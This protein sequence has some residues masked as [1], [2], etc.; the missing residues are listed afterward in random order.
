[1]SKIDNDLIKY[2][3]DF[4]TKDLLKINWS[5]T[6]IEIHNLIRGLSP[7]LDSKKILKDV[8]I[9]PSAWFLL[10]DDNGNKKRIKVQLTSLSPSSKNT[11]LSIDTDNFSY[12]KINLKDQSLNILRLQP[13]GKKSMNIKQFLQGNKI[14]NKFKI[15]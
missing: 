5:K 14:N 10:E 4:I 11:Y 6:P 3:K 1:M 15:L 9:C 7:V 2:L 12:F 8:S 13:E